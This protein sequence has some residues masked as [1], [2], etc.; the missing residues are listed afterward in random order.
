MRI[1]NPDEILEWDTMKLWNA[2]QQIDEETNGALKK[3]IDKVRNGIKLKIPIYYITQEW[4]DIYPT[5]QSVNI[6]GHNKYNIN[7][8][9]EELQEREKLMRKIIF[10]NID[11]EDPTISR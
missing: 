6:Y 4:Y 2:I 9:M 8:F 11:D 10:D 3:E 1:E 5:G 7:D